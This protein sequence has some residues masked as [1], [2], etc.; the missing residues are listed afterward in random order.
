[1]SYNTVIRKQQRECKNIN[2]EDQLDSLPV[3]RT[4]TALVL[5]ALLDR[6]AL[7]PTA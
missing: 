4:P 6:A 5:V 1:M 3:K 2:E 7:A